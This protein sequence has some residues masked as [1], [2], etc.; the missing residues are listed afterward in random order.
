MPRQCFHIV[1]LSENHA[2]T[3]SSVPRAT[4]H[5]HT[6]L[7]GSWLLIRLRPARQC[8]ALRVP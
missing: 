1:F 4:Q 7:L 5:S 2:Q 3:P 8:L 6:G